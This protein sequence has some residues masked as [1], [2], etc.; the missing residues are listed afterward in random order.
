MLTGVTGLAELVAARPEER[1]T[2]VSADLG[3]LTAPHP[4][5]RRS[6][7]DGVARRLD[8]RRPTEGRLVVAGAGGADDWWRVVAVAAWEHLDRTGQH[9]GHRGAD[10]PPR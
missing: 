8:G 10:G 1:P 7:D 4:D 9:V 2:Y 3:G 5:V 6:P